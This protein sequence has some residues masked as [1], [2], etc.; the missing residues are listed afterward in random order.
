LLE[1]IERDPSLLSWWR[2]MVRRW[3]RTLPLYLFCVGTLALLWSPQGDRN[4][5]LLSYAAFT[6][7][8]LWPMPQDNWFN[9]SWSLSIEEW[10]YLLFS[11]LLV[12]VVALTGRRRACAWGV[13]ALFVAAPTL[14]R[15]QTIAAAGQNAAHLR[16]I[17]VLRLDAITY[18]VVVAKLRHD[19]NPIVARPAWLA[20]VGIALLVEQWFQPIGLGRLPPTLFLILFFSASPMAFS[21]CLPAAMG[22]R[23]IPNALEFIVRRLSA[24]SYPLYLVHFA[25]LEAIDAG[26]VRFGVSGRGNLGRADFWRILCPAPRG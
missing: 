22:I 13:I 10:F 25:L 12:G 16:E 8:L 14:L 1:L 2:F 5:H 26:Q 23:Q 7:N 20:A 3:L 15:W 18:G 9:V 19:R 17:V 24:L 11:A 4:T 6:Q 21:L